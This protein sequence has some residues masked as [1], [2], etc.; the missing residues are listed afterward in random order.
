L[1]DKLTDVASNYPSSPSSHASTDDDEKKQKFR[2]LRK[3]HYNEMELVRK[4]RQEHP[5]DGPMDLGDDD[6]DNDADVE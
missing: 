3:H 1:Q 5:D 2:E 4:F 6:K